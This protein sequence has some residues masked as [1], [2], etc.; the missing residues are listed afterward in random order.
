[1]QA[2]VLA[3]RRLANPD[4]DVV[5]D[6]SGTPVLPID[7]QCASDG[8]PRP[9]RWNPAIETHSVA[10]PEAGRCSRLPVIHIR[11][12][13]LGSTPTLRPGL[14]G[15]MFKVGLNPIGAK[16]IVAK[17]VNAAFIGTDLDLGFRRAGISTVVTSRFSTDMGVS[18]SVRVGADLG[19]RM[20]VIV[21]P[22]DRF[23]LVNGKGTIIAAKEVHTAP[24][25]T[26]PTNLPPW[27]A[28]ADIHYT[29][30]ARDAAS[31][32]GKTKTPPADLAGGV[33]IG[34][35]GT[36]RTSDPQIRSLM[37]YPAELRARG[38][39]AHRGDIPGAQ[40]RYAQ[41]VARGFLAA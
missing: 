22:C 14:L 7:I 17:C 40:V 6:F 30:G 3:S 31:T 8:P 24:L 13:S 5:S 26:L 28:T 11:H 39:S 33:F 32:V 9:R 38:R 4:A 20:I 25:G 16:A 15:K 41:C 36:I 2:H 34:A 21:E 19:F 27:P 29:I 23:E 35:P 18:T 37:L 12:D 10:L 1:M